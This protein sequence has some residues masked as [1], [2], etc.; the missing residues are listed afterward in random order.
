VRN[1]ALGEILELHRR[2]IEQ[3]GGASGVR[4]QAALESSIGQPLQS[5]GGE[6]LYAGVV[7]KAA[8][9]GFFLA[10][11]HAFVDGNKRIAH[12]AM[13]VTLLLNGL[14]LL[15]ELN[16]QEEIMLRL[17][18]GQVSRTEFT[19]WVEQHVRASGT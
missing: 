7:A 11:N 2:L 17:A 8:A 19:R 13:E 18:S 1:L 6:E 10:T 15:A 5:F 4:D 9:L 16:E 14:E 3:F 12:A